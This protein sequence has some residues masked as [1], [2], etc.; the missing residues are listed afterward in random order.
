MDGFIDCEKISNLMPEFQIKLLI[1]NI[2][3][4]VSSI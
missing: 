1:T 4:L 2:N 3:L